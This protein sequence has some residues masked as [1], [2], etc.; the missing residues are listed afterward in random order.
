[1]MMLGP[2]AVGK[3]TLLATMYHE[4][5]DQSGFE[6][7]AS[8]DTHQNLLEAYQNLSSIITQPSFTQTG[9]LL[10]GTAGIVEHEFEI[11][12]LGKKEVELVFC[13]IAGGLI[14]AEKSGNPDFE[15]FKHK[16]KQATVIINVI[17]APALVEGDEQ[18]L[19]NDP[20]P[21]YER[22]LPTVIDKRNH[23]I[24][25]VITK[26]EAWLKNE[27]LQKKLEMAF[28]THYQRLLKWMEG[29]DNVAGVLIPVKTLG[30]VEFTRIDDQSDDH[31]VIFVRKPNLPFQPENTDQPL[32]Y[33]LAFALSQHDQNRLPWNKFVRWVS[34]KDIAFQKTL[35]EF[36]DARHRSFKIYGNSSLIGETK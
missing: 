31:K 34:N 5:D 7:S 3:T 15:E 6:L 25:F 11:R 30:C 26:C 28:E 1:M 12:F 33:A 23:L 32:R 27:S 14:R 10:K 16:L 20:L 4:F 22:L 2:D 24:L 29:L 36:A 35:T 13:D 21:F 19:V 18:L 9:Q 17:E 8:G